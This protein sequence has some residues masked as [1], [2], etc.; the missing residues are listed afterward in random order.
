MLSIFLGMWA[1][2]I[3]AVGYIET[4]KQEYE[5]RE[6][7]QKTAVQISK[8]I[9]SVQELL[10]FKAKSITDNSS[11][12]EAVANQDKQALLRILLPLKLSLRLDLVKIVDQQGDILADLRSSVVNSANLQ[13]ASVMELAQRGLLVDSLVVTE[14]SG[15]PLLIKTLSVTSKQDDVGSI[16]VGYALT[17]EILAEMLGAE[18][19]QIVLLQDSTPIVATLPIN[20][21]EGLVEQSQQVQQIQ[22]DDIAY[23]SQTASLPRIAND[24]FQMVVL[25]P[26]E[27]FHASQRQMWFVVYGIGLLGGLLISV[28]GIWTT[29]LITSRITRLTEATKQLAADDLSVSIP[30]EGNDEVA[31]LAKA[32]NNMTEQLKFRDFKIKTQVEELEWLVQQLQQIPEQV[33]VEKMAGLGQMVAGVAHEINNPVSFIYGNVPPAKEYV[34]DLVN[35]VRLYQKYL[36]EP[37]QEIQSLEEIVDIDFVIADLSKLLDSVESGA[38]RIREIVLSLR[39]FSRKDEAL[40]KA[41]NIHDGL[42]STLVIL[43][44][45]LK[46]RAERP[47]IAVIKNYGILPPVQCFAGEVNQVFMNL[48]SNSID[49]LEEQLQLS[50]T[51]ADSVTNY[52]PQIRLNTHLLADSWIA[53]SIA[54]N[55]PGIPEEIR[56]KLFEPFFTTKAVGKGT[57]LGLSIS[58]QI[59]V[60]KH[61][62]KIGCNSDPGRGTEFIIQLPLVQ[63]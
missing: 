17:P 46:A 9:A 3:A 5:L 14:E 62:G 18:R 51:S 15:S 25:T 37:P 23:L 24:E 47:A 33:H 8:E 7:T 29:R 27:E 4:S 22:L 19:Q 12:V 41:V 39:T 21:P 1:V 43:Q 54:D 32:F 42:D 13:D 20:N 63:P 45:R 50:P 40:M 55:G 52:Q 44:H 48:L 57:G 61:G 26:L 38:E 59:I 6:E 49:A 11:L 16:L 36:P 60:E 53:I 58:Y 31:I 34:R 30:V 10:S 56:S 2:G 28:A 35:L